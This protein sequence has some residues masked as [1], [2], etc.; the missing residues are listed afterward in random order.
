[1]AINASFPSFDDLSVFLDICETGGFRASAK[2]LGISP[3]SVSERIS[4]LESQ[5]GLPLLI[6][7][8]RS[9][10]PTDAGRSLAAR[11]APL[12]VD[13]RAALQDAASA[14]AEVRGVLRLN[15]TG[16][17]ME[18]ILPPIIDQFL[19]GHPGVRLEIVVEDRLVDIVASGC[20][21]GIRYGEH[22]AQDVI[23]VP[24]GPSVQRAGLAAAPS[25]LDAMGRPN[26]PNDVLGHDC[27]RLRY[28]SGASIG[29]EFEKEGVTTTVDPPAKLVVSVTA[30][31]AAINLAKNGHG[32]IYTFENWLAPYINS[33]ELEAVLTD[34]WPTFDGPRLYFSSRLVPAPLRAFIGFV[35]KPRG[36]LDPVRRLGT[37]D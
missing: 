28:T 22:L 2:R 12:Y 4:R 18:D 23:A 1:M 3:A 30:A 33:G 15:V 7:T 35:T 17:V 20:D 37:I 11:L 32:L 25:Y 27:I 24:I 31:P 9:V 14:H 16:A 34:W 29:W 26:Q 6:R 21:A 13:A 36:Q 8:T 10:T 19:V 5:V